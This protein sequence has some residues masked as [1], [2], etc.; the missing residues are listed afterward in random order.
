VSDGFSFF[1]ALRQI[2]LRDVL[3]EPYEYHLRHVF[4]WYSKTFST[5]LTEVEDL[6][7]ET[8]LQHFYE[9]RYEE[10]DDEARE[11]E[12][13]ILIESS[14]DEAR[15]LNEGDVETFRA[16][17]FEKFAEKQAE[18]DRVRIAKKIKADQE[19]PI[20]DMPDPDKRKKKHQEL[21]EPSLDTGGPL[22]GKIEPS[23]SM[24]FVSAAEMEEML[25]SGG[26]GGGE[27]D[28]T[29]SNLVINPKNKET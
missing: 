26:I 8:V 28:G 21:K 15:R 2:A 16:L 22:G 27:D 6:P 23:I 17:E 11:K 1:K 10:M 18:K 14:A 3:K 24:T 7:L 5:P 9:A 4:R 29:A 19:R 25:E 12:R 20:T 13:Q